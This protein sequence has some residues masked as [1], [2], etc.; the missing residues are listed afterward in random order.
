[1][2]FVLSL[3]AWLL[4]APFAGWAAVRLTGSERGFPLVALIAY[5][6]YVGVAAVVLALALVA[7]RRRLPAT[8]A[9]LAGLAL[10]AGVA[11]RAV[12]DDEVAG[13][14]PRLRVLSAN[15]ARGSVE[16]RV[17]TRMIRNR[18]VD[19]LSLQELTPELAAQLRRGPAG[20]ILPHAA[21]RTGVG[22]SGTGLMSRR[23]L[24]LRPM[25]A[26]MAN[27]TAVARTRW[28][29]F[30]SFEVLAVHPPPPT[31]A[32]VDGWAPDLRRLPRARARSRTRLLAG[33][34]NATLDHGEL[35]RLLARG[36][37]DA[38]A[39]AGSGLTGTWPSHRRL[40][41]VAIDHVLAPRS[42]RVVRADVLDLP[43]SD[44]RAVLAELAPPRRS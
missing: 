30:G 34:F 43:G 38:A 26:G 5:T 23:P 17:L 31:R 39:S 32:Q 28:P 14:G 16:A 4:V 15:V 36:Y 33:D 7:I 20:E 25:P 29:G 42:W 22:A 44:H 12:A 3:L 8:V 18:R 2:R 21:L 27:R 24:A 10:L 1:M 19:L 11:D 13:K 6:P 41:P 37:R 9:G 35:R 40:P